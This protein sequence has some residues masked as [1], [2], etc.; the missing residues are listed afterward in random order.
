MEKSMEI[1]MLNFWLGLLVTALMEENYFRSRLENFYPEYFI[2]GQKILK[3]SLKWQVQ[4][5]FLLFHV[6]VL[7]T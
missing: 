2:N 3:K 1:G 5:R 4:P 7:N 6:F